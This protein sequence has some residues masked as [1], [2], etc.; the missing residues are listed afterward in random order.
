MR[1]AEGTTHRFARVLKVPNF[2]AVYLAGLTSQSGRT[3][4]SVAIIWIVFATTKSA[5]DVAY[6][7]IVELAATIAF[8]LPSGVWI[9]RYDRVRLMVAADL[10]RAVTLGGLTV[11]FLWEGFQ[12]S[13]VL[14]AMFVV[15]AA[16]VLFQPAE[17]TLFP[18]I[19]PPE[20]LADA[21]GLNLASRSL[22][23]LVSNSIGG[24]LVITVGAVLGIL[25]NSLTFVVSSLFLLSVYRALR[26]AHQASRKPRA[27]PPRMLRELSEGFGWLI[28]QAPGLWQLSVSAL[29]M[30][31]F[32]TVFTTFV[33]VYVVENLHGT[34]LTYGLF[35]ATMTAG[36]AIGVLLVGRTAAVRHVGKV[37]VLGYGIGSG[38]GLFGLSLVSAPT[39]AFPL[40]F[41]YVVFSSFAGN[42]WLTAAQTMVPT[43][44]QGRYFALDGLLSW[45]VLPV[46][47][48]VGG[49]L[50][51]KYG[52]S[53]TIEFA[54]AGLLL[55]GVF[56]LAGRK[57]WRLDPTPLPALPEAPS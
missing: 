8:T 1:P 12:L 48:I 54:G 56:S 31:F 53:P 4:A 38:L 49:V 14:V 6:V 7:G 52:I 29:F 24:I 42:T 55:S 40:V 26:L 41:S 11:A 32:S 23:S 51:G 16:S 9:D 13:F 46:S 28:H 21:N 47:Q 57:L 5:M 34:S 2:R 37:W 27:A 44:V 20:D 35:L 17:Q 22:V 18:A 10:I 50:I 25:Y 19:L 15:S 36:S 3:I 30:N 45:G 39:L 43:G 33:V